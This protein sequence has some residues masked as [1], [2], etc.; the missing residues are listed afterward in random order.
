MATLIDR[1]RRLAGRLSRIEVRN[2][3][4][5]PVC[6]VCMYEPYCL[7]NPRPSALA[8]VASA[9]AWHVRRL[10]GR[11]LCRVG[12][13]D[14]LCVSQGE[15]GIGGPLPPVRFRCYR[16]GAARWG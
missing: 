12:R 3:H 4:G 1:I 15:A 13:H 10:A 5:N 9:T 7:C 2:A 14:W 8:V 16:C 6:P 11:L